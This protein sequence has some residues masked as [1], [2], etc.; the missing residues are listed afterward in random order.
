MSSYFRQ[1]PYRRLFCLFLAASQLMPL[2]DVN[3]SVENHHPLKFIRIV[4]DL[5]Q[6]P[7]TL[8]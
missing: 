6:K 2:P 7:F 5:A 4:P 8:K 1:L 3:E